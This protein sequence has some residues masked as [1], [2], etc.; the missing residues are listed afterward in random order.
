MRAKEMLRIGISTIVYVPSISRHYYE[1]EE[2][3]IHKI[4]YS[5][6]I[7]EISKYD[8]LYLHL[9]NIYPFSKANGWPIY[10]HILRTKI[11]F[12]IYVHGNEVQKYSSRFY[13]F[14]FRISEVLK[15][16]KKD[17]FVIPKMRR[18]IR[19]TKDIE[20]SAYIFPS[21]WMRN[22]TEENLN[23]K[24]D[25]FFIIPNGIDTALF[26]YRSLE[27]KR[28]KILTIRSLSQKVYNIEQTID[29]I[30]L[31]PEKYSLVI[32][33]KG[34][35]KR[36]YDRRIKALGLQHRIKII[37]Q[38]LSRI[39]MLEV[40]DQFGVFISTTRIDSQGITM[41]EAMSRGLLVA[42]TKNSS[43]G[44]FIENMKSGILGIDEKELFE[45][46]IEVTSDLEKYRKITLNGSNQIEQIELKKTMKKEIEVLSSLLSN[47][48]V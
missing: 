23:L 3:P 28:F 11:P 1:H 45:G 17:L 33:G 8:L 39:E 7:K 44:E 14:N 35:Y 40:F 21:K 2:I 27:E 37:E 22:N 9:L 4:G 48:D 30:N 32:Y 26:K 43:K 19:A 12:A 34:K 47:G 41:M 42:T 36:S 38:F 13:E 46:I 15:W 20:N 31:L 29:T 25:K 16:I 18:F 5:E 6:I 10:K 24:I